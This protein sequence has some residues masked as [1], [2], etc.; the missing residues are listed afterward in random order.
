MDKRYLRII[1]LP[2]HVSD[3]HAPMSM[4]NRAAQF[5]PFSALKG[6]DTAIDKTARRALE[7]QELANLSVPVP[8]ELEEHN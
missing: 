6:Y 1:D 2:H 7:E 5:A 4:Q 8:Q 3:K